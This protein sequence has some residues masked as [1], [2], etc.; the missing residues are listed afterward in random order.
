MHTQPYRS[1][2]SV[3]L[4]ISPS[5]PK[6]YLV[7]VLQE[8]LERP[9][10]NHEEPH[11]C[12][13]FIPLTLKHSSPSESAGNYRSSAALQSTRCQH[14]RV[15]CTN[16]QKKETLSHQ[17]EWP[18]VLGRQRACRVSQ[19]GKG[20]FWAAPYLQQLFHP[21]G[22]V[23]PLFHLAWHFLMGILSRDHTPDPSKGRVLVLISNSDF[24]VCFLF[25]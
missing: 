22:A 11:K 17:L 4:Q 5:V 25:S 20:G 24:I 13:G 8:Q 12:S 3:R 19:D 6:P 14:T 2:S 18:P 7:L 9:V 16:M 21:E 10:I 23:V 1:L 15:K